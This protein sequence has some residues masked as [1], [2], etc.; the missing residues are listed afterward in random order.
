M[1]T[2]RLELADRPERVEPADR[3]CRE[4]SVGRLEDDVV[5]EPVMVEG[6]EDPVLLDGQPRRGERRAMD[7][8]PGRDLI[9]PT[10]RAQDVVVR[11]AWWVELDVERL[12]V[13]GQGRVGRRPT[14]V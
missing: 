11:H 14:A 3:E 6:L 2:D 8:D 10:D 9:R 4:R 1:S 13:L 5:V 12:N 7:L